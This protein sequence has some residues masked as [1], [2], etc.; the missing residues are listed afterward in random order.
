MNRPAFSSRLA[1]VLTMAGVAVG[2]GNVWRFPYM[3]GEHGGFAFLLAYLVFMLLLAVPAMMCEWNLGRAAGT[4]PIGAFRQAFGGFGTLVGYA[5]VLNMLVLCTYYLIVIGQVAYS[6]L[7]AVVHGFGDDTRHAF[8]EG[9]AWGALQ[10]P[11]TLGLMAA[12]LVVLGLGVNRGIERI[13]RAIVPAFLAMIVIMAAVAMSLP[14][15][16]TGLADY[17]A[18]DFS[19]LTPEVLFAALGQV[20]FSI[21]LGGAAFVIY[22]SYLKPGDGDVRSAAWTAG[23]DV[24]AALL[25]S[26][27]IL[28]AVFAFGLDPQAGPTLLFNTLPEL[29]AGLPGG[30]WL[31]AV[32]LLTLA[33]VAFLSSLAALEAVVGSLSEEHPGLS[34]HLWLWVL[35]VVL[36]LTIAPVAF[37]PQVIGTLDFVFGTG[38]VIAGGLAA[39]LAFSW[40]LN[41][42]SRRAA[43]ADAGIRSGWLVTW[44]R[45]GVPVLLGLVMA[46]YFWEL[47]TA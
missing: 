28:P 12:T 37:N 21:G 18:P 41:R 3:L 6:G 4:G 19:K 9:L 34:R 13:S 16:F 43:L 33:A 35:G 15:G 39:V 11:L 36:A 32:F 5:I 20:G 8:D 44:I 29:F 10:Y 30:R 2:I 40:G 22:G 25:A 45:F 38:V 17:M 23:T 46:S 27:F 7:F 47:L 31:G 1:T 24:A 26:L 42:E 14:G